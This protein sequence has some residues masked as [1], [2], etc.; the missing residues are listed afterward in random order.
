MLPKYG[1]ALS[2]L[3]RLQM[4]VLIDKFDGFGW[5]ENVAQDKT[6][7]P[8]LWLEEGVTGPSEV[9]IFVF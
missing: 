9:S 3:A 4:N 5:F 8:V 2:A 7:L 6:Y 1:I